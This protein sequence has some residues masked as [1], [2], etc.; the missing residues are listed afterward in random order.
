MCVVILI[1]FWQ[2]NATPPGAPAVKPMSRLGQ[3]RPHRR[4]EAWSS[5]L[6]QTFFSLKKVSHF[7]VW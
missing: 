3:L 4:D 5:S 7:F 2:K 1:L 6:C